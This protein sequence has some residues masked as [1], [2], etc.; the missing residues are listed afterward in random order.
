MRGWG[1]LLREREA[2]DWGFWSS[3]RKTISMRFASSMMRRSS[4]LFVCRPMSRR[5]EMTGVFSAAMCT[6]VGG[7]LGLPTTDNLKPELA[8]IFSMACVSGPSKR[9]VMGADRVF[10][11]DAV[12]CCWADPVRMAKSA[13]ILPAASCR[14]LSTRV[15]AGEEDGAFCVAQADTKKQRK[16]VTSR[17]R[18]VWENALL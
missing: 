9:K 3:A 18:V 15:P 1:Q 6:M 4:L 10:A 7:V 2:G 12:S 8:Q 17:G 13:R 14:L 5:M 16:S 11:G